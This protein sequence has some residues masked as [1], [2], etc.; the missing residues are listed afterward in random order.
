[1]ES[2]T[3]DNKQISLSGCGNLDGDAALACLRSKTV[4]EI[5]ATNLPALWTPDDDTFPKDAAEAY[6]K[7]DF[8]HVDLLTGVVE[9]EGFMI[10]QH[11]IPAI[12]APEIDVVQYQQ[13]L[14]MFLH[15]QF[16]NNVD[17]IQGEIM[18]YYFGGDLAGHDADFVRQQT[19]DILGSLVLAAP[20]HLAAQHHSGMI[21]CLFQR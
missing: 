1:M 6:S 8:P 13:Q 17:K 5:L 12:S 9:N 14:G 18:E 15:G 3:V 10:V 2:W 19:S 21:V 4:E 20:T 16:G 11:V 7:G